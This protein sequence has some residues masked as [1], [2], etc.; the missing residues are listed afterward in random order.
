MKKSIITIAS[1][2]L[3]A[4][5]SVVFYSCR[6]KDKLL[7]GNLGLLKA[8]ESG[9]AASQEQINEQTRAIAFCLAGATDTANLTSPTHQQFLEM[10]ENEGNSFKGKVTT[11]EMVK[12]THNHLFKDKMNNGSTP[13]KLDEVIDNV[14]LYT[15][16]GFIYLTHEPIINSGYHNDRLTHFNFDFDEYTYYVKILDWGAA[17]IDP[18]RFSK[19][20]VFIPREFD[21]KSEDKYPMIGYYYNSA[22]SEVDSIMWQ[23]EDEFEDDDRFYL[24]KVDYDRIIDN[25]NGGGGNNDDCTGENAPVPNDYFC[26]S[27]CGENSGTSPNDCQPQYSRDLKLTKFGLLRDDKNR[28]EDFNWRETRLAGLAEISFV[29][30]IARGNG[31]LTVKTGHLN[32]TWDFLEVPHDKSGRTQCKT[33]I[34]KGGAYTEV[35]PIIREYHRL[36]DYQYLKS[37]L[38]QAPNDYN[39]IG[40]N[41]NPARD[42]IIIMFYEYDAHGKTSNIEHSYTVQYNKTKQFKIYYYSR[43]EE[44]PMADKKNYWDGKT[45]YLDTSNYPAKPFIIIKPSDWPNANTLPPFN[46]FNYYG[47]DGHDKYNCNFRLKYE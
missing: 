13:Y 19:K 2:A 28:C 12:S 17:N 29:C 43:P 38:I 18:S 36:F 41:F 5:I 47:K 27:I 4:I 37:Y 30:V 35:N 26:D 22:N 25:G 7:K 15:N 23:T 39:I 3:I 20:A 21:N 14:N 42:T 46:T 11:F 45:M 8:Q 44:G 6:K 9:N 40:E 10:I 24:F 1:I 33:R 16:P 34:T 32:N 31:K